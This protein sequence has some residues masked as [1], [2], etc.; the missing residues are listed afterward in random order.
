M[1]LEHSSKNKKILLLVSAIILIAGVFLSLY[2]SVIFQEGNPWPQIKGIVQLK[3]GDN[4]IVK[5]SGSDNKFMTESKNGTMIH[6][7]MKTKGYEFT[8]QIGSGYFFKSATGQTTIATHKYYSRHYS[9]W[10][11]T[12]NTNDSNNLWT[13]ITNDQGVTFQYPKELLAKYVSVAEWPPVIKIETG[14][15]SCEITPQE[16]SSMLEIIGQRLVDNRIYCVNVKN[17]GVAGIVYSSYVYTTPKR[18]KLVS[19][20]FVLRY[21]SCANYDEEQNQSC[22]NEREAFDLDATVDR[23]VQTV[24]WDSIFSEDTL[25]NQILKC[26]ASSYSGDKEKCDELLKQINDFDSCVM[27]GFSIMKSNP[28]QCATLDGRT[29]VEVN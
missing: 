16:K 14:T 21:P 15:Y 23:I 28:P 20:S 17:E 3:F 13:T 1:I 25:A 6:D 9:L 18:G 5:L 12:E 8:E 24:S 27:A 10:T 26:L 7:F 2:S 29:F 11:I 19:V 4:D 22:V